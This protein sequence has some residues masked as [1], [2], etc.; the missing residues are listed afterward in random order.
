MV[1]DSGVYEIVCKKT[2]TETHK[3]SNVKSDSESLS[4]PAVILNDVEPSIKETDD[5]TIY[6]KVEVAAS[7]PGGLNALQ[8]ALSSRLVYPKDAIQRGEVGTVIVEFV[9]EKDGTLSN[10]TILRL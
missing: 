3:A 7:Y 10:F 6:D 1:D 4:Q 9:V 8:K 2:R 5:N